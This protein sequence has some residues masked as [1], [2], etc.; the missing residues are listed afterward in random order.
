ME[1]RELGQRG[2]AEE[3]NREGIAQR[4]QRKPRAAVLPAVVNVDK[5]TGNDDQGKQK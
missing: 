1:R 3:N 4:V 5:K 2:D